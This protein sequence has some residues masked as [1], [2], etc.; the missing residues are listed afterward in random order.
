[1][2]MEKTLLERA[3][4]AAEFADEKF[5]ADFPGEPS[6]ARADPRWAFATARAVLEAIREPSGA[7]LDDIHG[8]STVHDWRRMIDVILEAQDDES[9]S[10]F[11]P[12]PDSPSERKR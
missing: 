11:A 2:G 6:V 4:R 1:M 10:E 12:L 5:V 9:R 8:C 3:A 7:L